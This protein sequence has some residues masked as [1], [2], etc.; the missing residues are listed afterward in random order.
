M[1]LKNFHVPAWAFILPCLVIGCIP[2]TAAAEVHTLPIESPPLSEQRSYLGIS[3]DTFTLGDVQADI[4]IV[5]LFS[6]YCALC[7]KEA[8]AIAELYALAKK[9]PAHTGRIVLLGIGAGN[10]A[11]EVARFQKKYSVPFPMVPDK[12]MTVARSMKMA[13]TPAFIAFKKNADGSLVR[14]HMRFGV[15]GPP[16]RFLDSTL[17]AAAA[18]P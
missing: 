18:L 5:E 7:A 17:Q 3:S 6:L 15:L 4:I 12:Q 9:P 14:L 1:N 10:S 16:Q 13:I 8:P 2:L 11:D